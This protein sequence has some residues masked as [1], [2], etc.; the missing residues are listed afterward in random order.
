[1]EK[2]RRTYSYVSRTIGTFVE[3]QK[4]LEQLVQEL[5]KENHRQFALAGE[6]DILP[7]VEIT[8]RA[9]GPDIRYRVLKS[10]ETPQEGETVLDCTLNGRN[11]TYGISVLSRLLKTTVSASNGKIPSR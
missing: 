10:G 3:Y 9:L 8:L 4:R 11:G 5:V 2:A 1:M 6:G 7:L